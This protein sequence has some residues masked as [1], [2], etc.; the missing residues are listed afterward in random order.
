MPF[1]EL[2][3]KDQ[4]E[5]ITERHEKN[6]EILKNDLVKATSLTLRLAKPGLQYVL[7]CDA[8]YYGTGFVLMIEDYIKT[9][10]KQKKSYAPV[11][12]GSR[13]FNASQLKFSVYY[14]EFLGLY[15]AQDHFSHF[16]WGTEKP[17]IVLTDNKS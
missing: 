8:S 12:F 9:Q 17:V 11:A 13:L 6:L 2:L 14:K 3:R 16:I 7:L 15:F 1:Y 4:Q 10:N 5:M